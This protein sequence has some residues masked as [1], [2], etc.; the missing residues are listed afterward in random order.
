MR[1]RFKNVAEL[2]IRYDE[3]LCGKLMEVHFDE[4]EQYQEER[5][6][7]KNDPNDHL[8]SCQTMW[9]LQLKNE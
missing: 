1:Y 3:S 2:L 7:G 9:V 4:A 8:I 6:D 5:Y